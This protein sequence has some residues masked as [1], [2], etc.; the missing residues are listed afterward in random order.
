MGWKKRFKRRVKKIKNKITGNAYVQ[1]LMSLIDNP[2]DFITDL[3]GDLTGTAQANEIAEQNLDLAQETFA[4]Q[5]QLQQQVFN[6]EDNAMQR[7]VA[8]LKAAGLS[9]VLATGMSPGSGPT[10]GITGPQK[11]VVPG[12]N[13]A[14]L[15]S[16]VMSL[17]TNKASIAKTLADATLSQVNAAKAQTEAYGQMQ[18]NRVLKNDANI[19]ENS[20]VV[21]KPGAGVSQIRDLGSMFQNWFDQIFSD[22]EKKKFDKSTQKKIKEKEQEL[23][24]FKNL[25]NF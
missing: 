23:E 24:V 2:R 21:S 17:L 5:Q 15:A 19:I 7:R 10:V 4:Y 14:G 3:A 16:T 8:D 13:V 12:P 9:P 18:K 1:D 6:R 20:G 25:K 22:E 11:P